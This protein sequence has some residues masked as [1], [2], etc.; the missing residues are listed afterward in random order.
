MFFYSKE[1][2]AGLAEALRG[3]ENRNDDL[4]QVLIPFRYAERRNKW[5]VDKRNAASHM[6]T[7]RTTD[8]RVTTV[9]IVIMRLLSRSFGT[10]CDIGS[11]KA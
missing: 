6:Q 5:C 1:F 7:F 8:R 11:A 9:G 10:V 3:D 4:W 2:S